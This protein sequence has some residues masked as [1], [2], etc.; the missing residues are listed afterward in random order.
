[1]SVKRGGN[2]ADDE[3]NALLGIEEREKP[4]IERKEKPCAVCGEPLLVSKGQ[5][6][7]FHKKCRDKRH[8]L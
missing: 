5:R 7:T 2:G 6:Y 3:V 8:K 1:M 4:V